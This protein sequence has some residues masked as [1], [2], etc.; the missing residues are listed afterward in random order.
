MDGNLQVAYDIPVDF[1]DAWNSMF[2]N[3]DFL[4]AHT[5]EID[6]RHMYGVSNFDIFRWPSLEHGTQRQAVGIMISSV[7]IPGIPLVRPT[8]VLPQSSP[9]AHISYWQMFYGEEQEFYM[10]DTGAANYLYG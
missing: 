1:V 5:G 4:N 2:Q 8:L 6:P 10:Y 3:N 9:S 7:V